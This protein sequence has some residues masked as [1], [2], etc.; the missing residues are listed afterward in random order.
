MAP[1][2][3]PAVEEEDWPMDDLEA[4]ERLEAEARQS[5]PT[6]MGSTAAANANSG[7]ATAGEVGR[8]VRWHQGRVLDFLGNLKPGTD[9][10]SLEVRLVLDPSAEPMA[11]LLSDAVERRVV[12]LPVAEFKAQ[13]RR[14][15]AEPSVRVALTRRLEE[16]SDALLALHGLFLLGR[17]SGD[18]LPLLALDFKPTR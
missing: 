8:V 18:S 11:V 17:R 15:K 2:E 3:T 9:G 10:W 7:A 16:A 5:S 4:L 13:R 1:Q 14:A 12:G 6:Q